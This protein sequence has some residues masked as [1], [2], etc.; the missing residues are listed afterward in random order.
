MDAAGRDS[1][2]RTSKTVGI[3]CITI[4]LLYVSWLKLPAWTPTWTLLKLAHPPKANSIPLTPR[5]YHGT[6]AT[7]VPTRAGL[8]SRRHTACPGLAPCLA[9]DRGQASG[10]GLTL[11]PQI[12]DPTTTTTNFS[13]TLTGLLTTVSLAIPRGQTSAR[14]SKSWAGYL[15]SQN[16]TQMWH[17]LAT[18]GQRP[19]GQVEVRIAGQWITSP[20]F[21]VSI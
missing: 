1:H 16:G 21:R 19:A 9:A 10:S 18:K 14:F 3:P 17:G 20:S 7:C 6:D 11:V 4:T 13:R 12:L 8:A 2:F 5:S 15:C